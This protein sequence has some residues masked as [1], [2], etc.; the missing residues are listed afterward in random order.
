MADE[1]LCGKWLAAPGLQTGGAEYKARKETSARGRSRQGGALTM[2][3]T[4]YLEAIRQAMLEEMDRDPAVVLI[5]EDVGV[6]GG[7]F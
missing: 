3:E 2:P 6:Y 7:A 5:G 4:T 1:I